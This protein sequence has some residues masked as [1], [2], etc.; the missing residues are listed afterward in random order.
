MVSCAGG[1]VVTAVRSG[2]TC[3]VR[4]VCV[5]CAVRS[6]VSHVLCVYSGCEWRSG[7]CDVRVVC[8]CCWS[9]CAQCCE[10]WCVSHVL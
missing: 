3:A 4:S 8:Q 7:S 10:E 9:G 1:V 2:I 5:T 6:G